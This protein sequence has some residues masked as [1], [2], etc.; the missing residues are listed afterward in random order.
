MAIMSR[1][2]FAL[3]IGLVAALFVIPAAALLYHLYEEV[4]V[5]VRYSE[6]ELLGVQYIM[7]ARALTRSLQDHRTASQLAISGDP[8]A[9]AQLDPIADDVDR[10]LGLLREINSKTGARLNTSSAF[11]N[12]TNLWADI[13]TNRLNFTVTE[14]R[15][16][17]ADIIE[18]VLAYMALSADNS[19]LTVDPDMNSFYLLDAAIFRVPGVAESVSGLAALGAS[20]IA[21]QDMS[22]EELNELASLRAVLDKDFRAV[23]TD[24]AKFF[25]ANPGLAGILGPKAGQALESAENFL[26]N[27]TADLA[28]GDLTAAIPVYTSHASAAIEATY[29]LFDAAMEQLNSLLRD[30]VQY[31]NMEL[32]I[33]FGGAAITLL[34]MLYF[35]IGELLSIL[36]S[37]K[38][39]EAGA[40]RLAAGDV[41]MHVHSRSRDELRRLGDAVNSVAETLQKFTGAQLEMA[42]AHRDEGKSSHEMRVSDFAGV[43]GEIAS[44]L[45]A[46]VKCELDVRRLFVDRMLEYSTGSFDNRLQELPGDRRI[47]SGIAEALRVRL[48]EAQKAA[49]DSL[50]VKLALDYSTACVMVVDAEGIIQ[51]SNKATDNL[52]HR[53]AT[54]LQRHK[55]D[56]SP[57]GVHGSHFSDFHKNPLKV[58]ELVANLKGEHRAQIQLGD[59]HFLLIANP[60]LDDNGERLGT[61]VQFIDRTIQ[62]NAEKEVAEIVHAAAAGDFSKRIVE[63]D[64]AGFM[65]QMAQGLNNVLATSEQA[66]GEIR[67]I[68]KGLAEGDVSQT[69][70]ADFQ[71]V[72]ADLKNDTNLT[73]EQLRGIIA[74][75]REA[76]DCINTAAHKISS[77]NE[78]LL[79][80]TSEQASSLEGTAV[81]I[82]KLAESVRQTTENAMQANSVAFEAY[83]SA[84]RGGEVVAQAVANMKAITERNKEVGEITSLIDAIA[85]QTNLLALNAAIEAARAGEHG[86]GFSVVAGEVRALAQRAATAAKQIK[87]VINNTIGRVEEGAKLV[88]S[89]GA[90]IT[91]LV[92]QVQRVTA[93]ILSSASTNSEHSDSVQ[94]VSET[95]AKIDQVT[96]QNAGL[97]AEVTATAQSLEEQAKALVSAV[98]V[99]TMAKDEAATEPRRRGEKESVFEH[100]A[101]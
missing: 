73:I 71:G 5:K 76:S 56:F 48:M 11:I 92:S 30:R 69:I 44:N 85:F 26:S 23:Q 29:A 39:I 17:H 50:K 28:R 80:R 83:E 8:M 94:K 14:S 47:V 24:L 101:C 7:P 18:N 72:F 93:I 66:L 96:Q 98:S 77:S 87:D 16:K 57:S 70:E 40:D 46:M 20:L 62:M 91:D 78:N 55:P 6:S 32:R 13:K 99:F 31:L 81:N 49:R 79:K 53:F 2:R 65:L 54:A 86:R 41:S 21:R 19:G 61:F 88:E 59:L 90:T 82:A 12:I 58:R 100:A 42:R 45:N 64:K 97:F 1:L 15:K 37:L 43:Y 84:G 27:D 34:V 95:I 51:Y 89:T 25:G 33:V 35:M 52:L 60:M 3:K 75:I 67:R 22:P 4:D 63:A 10:N 74:R 9:K 68:L 38:S 36:R